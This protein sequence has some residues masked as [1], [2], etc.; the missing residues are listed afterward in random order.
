MKTI[1]RREIV[2][3][4]L[5]AF[6]GAA[7]MAAGLMFSSP[8][9]GQNCPTSV[10]LSKAGR[11]AAVR[12]E[13]TI[14]AQDYSKVRRE[15]GTTTDSPVEARTSVEITKQ[16]RARVQSLTFSCGRD[17]RACPEEIDIDEWNDGA[18]KGLRFPMEGMQTADGNCLLRM[19]AYVPTIADVG[20]PKTR[21]MARGPEKAA[22]VKRAK[23]RTPPV[24]E[25]VSSREEPRTAEEAEADVPE[26]H[27]FRV[28]RDGFISHVPT[29]E[30]RARIRELKGDPEAP[31]RCT[32][33][34]MEKSGFTWMSWAIYKNKIRPAIDQLKKTLGYR[35]DAIRFRASVSKGGAVELIGADGIC[36]GTMCETGRSPLIATGA[37]ADGFILSYSGSDC[38]LHFDAPLDAGLMYRDFRDGKM[39]R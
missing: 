30:Q 22:P 1:Q 16:G 37:S 3:R 12:F 34:D 8:A 14:L 13:K 24:K 36:G 5:K 10:V 17:A 21:P 4:R 20:I 7:L 39:L 27:Q 11:A 23:T 26:L 38:V 29:K 31:R 6:A 19:S 15:L 33:N 32:S 25:T 2:P 18:V 28:D 9:A 35:L